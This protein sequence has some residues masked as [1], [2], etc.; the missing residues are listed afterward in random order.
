[1]NELEKRSFYSFLGLYLLSSF[2]LISLVGYWYFISQE[3]ALQSKVHAKLE[4]VIDKEASRIISAQMEG[5]PYTFYPPM[6]DIGL[7]LLDKHGTRISGAHLSKMQD[8]PFCMAMRLKHDKESNST[9]EQ[10]PLGY[11]DENGYSVLISDATKGHM[12]VARIVAST[13]ILSESIVAL[14]QNV[15]W[16]VFLVMLIVTVIAWMLSG[17]FMRPVRERR[18]QIERFINDVTHEL[19]T[20]I[21]SLSMSA[22]QALSLGSCS[23]KCLNHISISTRQ[24]YDIYR[25]LTYLSFSGVS[26]QAEV[27]EVGEVLQKSVTYYQPLSQIKRITLETEIGH[28]LYTIPSQQLSLL[29]GNLIG[30]AIKYSPAGSVIKISLKD[31]LF[32]IE[33]QGIGIAADEQTKIYQRFARATRQSGGFGIGLSIVKS[34]C[35]QYGID[36]ALDSEPGRGTTFRL[37]FGITSGQ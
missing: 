3:R 26:D 13:K 4:H 19:N 25:S 32:I 6:E 5:T 17:I 11:Y 24:L 27:V 8:H 18:I 30:N 9:L 31:G 1:M 2:L 15:L 22:E 12:G 37:F 23:P 34:I 7:T 14:R 36:I 29:F 10:Y 33:D 28:G 16:S 21:T 20:P 35:D